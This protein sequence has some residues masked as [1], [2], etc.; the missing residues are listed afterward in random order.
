VQTI[1]GQMGDSTRYMGR[2]IEDLVEVVRV[3]SGKLTMTGRRHN[4]SE[5]VKRAVGSSQQPDR[6]VMLTVDLPA[7]LP[8]VFVD[9]DR[10]VQVLVNLLSNAIKF[11][12]PGGEVRVVARQFGDEVEVR[13]E[14]EGCGMSPEQVSH[15]FDRFW[16][17]SPSDRRGLGLGLAIAKGIVEAGGGRIW[18]ES[19]IGQGTRFYFTLPAMSGGGLHHL[20]G[21]AA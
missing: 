6:K 21:V 14:D 18:V 4:L 1:A 13:V 20:A 7:R 10:V 11:T 12:P 8:S 19:A 17:A 5:L 9:G 2:L 3:E 16:Q 15:V